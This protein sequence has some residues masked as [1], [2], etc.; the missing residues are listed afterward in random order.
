MKEE[1]TEVGGR[2][3]AFPHDPPAMIVRFASS[4][5]TTT[6]SPHARGAGALQAQ[7]V[8]IRVMGNSAWLVF[9]WTFAGKMAN[10]QAI[11]SKGWESHVYERVGREWRISH[12]HYSAQMPPP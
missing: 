4:V 9:D 6:I 12:L 2:M 7:N 8:A 10:G 1:T 3:L 11:N 5:V